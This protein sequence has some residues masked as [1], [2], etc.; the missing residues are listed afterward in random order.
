[1]KKYPY[2]LIIITSGFPSTN[3]SKPGIA[4]LRT[5]RE[6]DS[7]IDV[8]VPA[9]KSKVNENVFPKG[10]VH[11]VRY[12][13]R[14]LCL[15]QSTEGTGGIPVRIKQNPFLLL[16]VPFVMVALFIKT[17]RLT[18]NNSIIHAQWLPMAFIAAIIKKI[19]DTPFLVTLRGAD[20]AL[21]KIKLLNP[22][23]NW[24]FQSSDAVVT[25]SKSLSTE[26]SEKFNIQSKTYFIP[27][28]VYV[29]SR[30]RN[31][32]NHKHII[33]FV[34]ALIPRK[35]VDILI[36]AYTMAK[37]ESHIH[38]MIGGDGIERKRLQS[39]VHGTNIEENI[40]FLGEIPSD[41]VQDLMLKS[42]CFVLPSYSEGTPNV[43]KEAMACGIPVIATNVS[44]NPELIMHNKTG[45]L[46]EPGDVNTLSNHLHFAIDNKNIMREMGRKGKEFIISEKLTWRNCANEYE[47][48]YKNIQRKIS[49]P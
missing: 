7:D 39:M 11:W 34:G 21:W 22:I 35:G 12:M 46:F 9:T 16:F 19:K 43:I 47:K 26:I 48:I 5:I 28:G 23:V 17:Y 27:N 6:I 41:E 20:Q 30:K 32:N 24:I 42:N 31:N 10:R 25:V 29:P 2:H 40:T 13:P 37:F 14:I 45:L 44:G 49:R 15:L 36:Q 38:L 3:S 18:R 1:M 33:L 8:V 4:I